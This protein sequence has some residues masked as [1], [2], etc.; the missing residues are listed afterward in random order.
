[1]LRDGVPI[2]EHSLRHVVN[3]GIAFE[4]PAGQVPLFEEWEAG[5]AAGLDMWKWEAGE[6]PASFKARAIAWHAK[7]CLV[8]MHKND[9][10]QNKIEQQARR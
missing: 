9:A 6:Y 5:T 1:M 7:H 3:A 4:S 10:Q 8:E 2:E